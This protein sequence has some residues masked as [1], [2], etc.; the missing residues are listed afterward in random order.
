MVSMRS[1][2]G[3]GWSQRHASQTGT[4][5]KEGG[6]PTF[7][8]T[9]FGGRDLQWENERPDRCFQVMRDEEEEEEE[10]EE[11]VVVVKQ[12]KRSDRCWEKVQR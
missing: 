2:E 5:E 1:A 9:Q 3:M 6:S 4:G 7:I 10:E 12:R 11:E 8:H